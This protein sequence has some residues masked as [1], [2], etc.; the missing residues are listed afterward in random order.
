MTLI[1]LAA[2]LLGICTAQV[3]GLARAR[4]ALAERDILSAV[5]ESYSVAPIQTDPVISCMGNDCDTSSAQTIDYT[6][7][8]ARHDIA[9]ADGNQNFNIICDVDYAGQNIYPFILAGSFKTCFGHCREYNEDHNDT[10]CMGFVYAPERAS[11]ADDCYLK[12]SVNEPASATVHLVGAT[13]A[14][15]SSSFVPSATGLSAGDTES[16]DDSPAQPQIAHMTVK[17]V[18]DLGSSTN[19]P[20][21]QYV[22]HSPY[23]PLKLSADLTVP[24]VNL[25]LISDYSLAK[26]TGSWKSKDFVIKPVIKDMSTTPVISRDGGKGGVV[27]GTNIFLFCDTSIHSNGQFVAFVSS[28]V[29]TDEDMNGLQDKS[30]T[31]VDHIGEWQ[32]DVGRMRGFAP[33]TDGEE[34]YNKAVSGD[35]ARYAV[36]PESAPI[37]LNSSTSL[38]YAS[39]VYDE[40]D[41]NNQENYNLTYF[42][43]TLL[44]TR[45]DPKFG[46]YAD[47]VLPQLFH[48]GQIPFGSLAGFRAWGKEGKGGND[49]E[50]MLFGKAPDHKVPGVYAA[51]TNCHDYKNLDSYTY[52]NGHEWTNTMPN[53]DQT[54]A[55]FF[56]E[57][58]VDLD[59]V[60]N[61]KAN[62][63]IM[64]YTVFPPD[65]KFYY[66]ELL[67]YPGT[68]NGV[69]P[70]YE[71]YGDD[72]WADTIVSGKWDGEASLLYQVKDP[73]VGTMYAGGIHAG[74]FGDED[75]TNGGNSILL[76]WTE[77]TGKEGPEGYAHRVARARIHYGGTP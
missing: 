5:P 42:G 53:P 45:V 18:K 75:I 12:S 21:N 2:S 40:V 11:G 64:I 71:S 69:F 65:N 10:Q 3:H 29:A 6:C 28:S 23:Q 15:S 56:N 30:L 25:D 60:Y 8:N 32:D 49:G 1:L 61:P 47:R 54:E 24:G 74:Y 37:A 16:N 51:K 31:L 68:L 50:I 4:Q 19:N 35:G 48:E 20:T 27:N 62:T 34:A 38:I 77:H 67:P 7:D 70:P 17:E 36:W 13:L 22:S 52:W 73:P 33:M 44:E 43:N 58:V 72:H 14:A 66:R 9:A 39:L 55:S 46:P 76:T 41:M 57:Y 26:D 59:M 63:F